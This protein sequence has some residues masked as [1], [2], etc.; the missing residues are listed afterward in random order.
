[1]PSVFLCFFF[2]GGGGIKLLYFKKNHLLFK[3]KTLKLQY[4]LPKNR[5]HNGYVQIE[6]LVYLQSLF[7][8]LHY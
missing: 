1:M 4:K 2:G 8:E 3:S 5:G 6:N 7:F